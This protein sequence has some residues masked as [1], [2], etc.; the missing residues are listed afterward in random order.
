MEYSLDILTEMIRQTLYDNFPYDVKSGKHIRDVAF[1]DLPV[2]SVDFGTDPY[3]MFNIGS[4]YAEENAPY[5]H[6]LQDAQYIRKSGF[7]TKKSKGSQ[8]KVEEISKRD[9]G[10]IKKNGPTFS[11][12]YH[13]ELRGMRNTKKLMEATV[14]CQMDGKTYR[15]NKDSEYYLNVHYNYIDRALDEGLQVVADTLGLKLRRKID[16]GLEDEYKLQQVEDL[17]G[18]TESLEDD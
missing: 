9:Y 15:I 12:E 17:I 10:R 11:K 3:R 6:I 1:Y 5:Y 4:D 16:T 8:A 13:K 2:I 14:V 18:F 7:G